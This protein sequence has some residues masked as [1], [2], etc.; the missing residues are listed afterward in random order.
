MRPA[1]L[2]KVFMNVSFHCKF[3]NLQIKTTYLTAFYN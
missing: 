1:E 2:F 3:Y